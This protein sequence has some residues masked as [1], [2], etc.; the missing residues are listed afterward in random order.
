[1]TDPAP[2]KAY[3]LMTN[4]LLGNYAAPYLAYEANRGKAIEVIYR[5][6]KRKAKATTFP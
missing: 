2:Y 1:M 3:D 5:P 6:S 4:E